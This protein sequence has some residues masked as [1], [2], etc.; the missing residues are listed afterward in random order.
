M[1]VGDIRK[2]IEGA[3][4]DEEIVVSTNGFSAM[5]EANYEASVFDDY[6]SG[7]LE[8]ESI[9]STRDGR[10]FLTIDFDVADTEEEQEV[11]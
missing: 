1:T 7:K 6:P 3:Y 8:L 9:R 2:A 4:D 10:V 11:S 5:L